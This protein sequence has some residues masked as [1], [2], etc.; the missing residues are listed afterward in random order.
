MMQIV[1]VANRSQIFYDAFQNAY[2]GYYPC[3]LCR[4]GLDEGRAAIGD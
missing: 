3:E 4:A 2:P 1:A